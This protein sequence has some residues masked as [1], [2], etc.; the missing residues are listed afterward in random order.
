MRQLATG[1]LTLITLHGLPAFAQDPSSRQTREF[2]QAAAQ[3]DQFEILEGTTALAESKDPN[4]RAFAAQMIGVH[5]QSTA[6]LLNAV[7]SAGLKPPLPGL[8]GD[9]SQFL[10]ALQSQ[11][12]RDFDKSYVRQQVLVHRAALAVAQAY[13]SDSDGV[14]AFVRTAA[15]AA[16]LVIKSHLAM[17]EQMQATEDGS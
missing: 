1:T 15:A 10:A 4:V 2:V 7:A 16:V 6:D 14:N 17:A 5:R 13:A 9:Q 12:G 11:R 8:N 3:T